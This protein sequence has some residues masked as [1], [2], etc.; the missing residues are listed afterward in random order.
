MVNLKELSKKKELFVS[1]HRAC[2]GCGAALIARHVMLA[3]SEKVVVGGATGCLEVF[4]TIFPY[5]AWNCSFIHS[6]FENVAATLSGAES[7]YK[8]LK[9]KGVIKDKIQFIAF[10]GDG[11]TYDIGLQS[12]SGVFERGHDV[13]YICY[14]N[15][16]YSNTGFQRSSATPEYSK[17]STTPVS[18]VIKGKQGLRK[19]ITEIMVA[20]Q[21]P[22]VA[23]SA[24]GF[25]DDL[26]EKVQRALS[27]SG[28]KFINILSTCV[29]GWGVEP[30]DS[31]EV[32]RR[33]VESRFWPLYEVKDGIYKI[34][35]IPPKKVSLVDF[36]K[37]QDRFQYLLKPENKDLLRELKKNVEK[38][39]QKLL[40][41]VECS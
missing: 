26:V 14:D 20:H 35:Y 18:K 36:F 28:P 31:L 15:Q 40:K 41:K 25:W 9:K 12:L 7:A 8:A 19:D 13:L 39:W 34:N 4:S 32:A 33:A 29:L 21:I 16:A 24:V 1:G 27:I 23:Q 2:P 3:A 6:A 17:T 38:N 10:G 11:G 37:L 30:K 22:Y 5:T